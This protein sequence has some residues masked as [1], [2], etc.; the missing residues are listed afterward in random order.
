MN[1]TWYEFVTK[2]WTMKRPRRDEG[3]GYENSTDRICQYH[4]KF[5]EVVPCKLDELKMGKRDRAENHRDN[6][7]RNGLIKHYPPLWGTEQFEPPH[8]QTGASSPCYELKIDGSGTPYESI[9]D[10]RRDKLL[11]HIAVDNWTWI[12]GFELAHFERMSDSL[13]V[14][15]FLKRVEKHVGL[16]ATCKN[17]PVPQWKSKQN[18]VSKEYI[19]WITDRVDWDV[20]SLV[21]YFPLRNNSINI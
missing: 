6:E 8:N 4:F 9:V 15:E 20:E 7:K 11:N 10:M 16:N 13:Y 17:I 3:F 5:N 21:G 1:L 19:D 14:D 12:K 2:P 18:T